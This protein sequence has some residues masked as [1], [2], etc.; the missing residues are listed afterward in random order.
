[1]LKLLVMPLTPHDA[2][3]RHYSVSQ[4]LLGKQVG[5][6]RPE[7]LLKHRKK[8]KDSRGRGYNREWKILRL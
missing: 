7:S 2:T 3:G 4:I 6:P 8:C 1:M 5:T